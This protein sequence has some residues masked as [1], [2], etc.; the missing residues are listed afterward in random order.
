MAHQESHRENASP[1][2]A[3]RLLTLVGMTLA[4]FSGSYLAYRYFQVADWQGWLADVGFIAAVI[5]I[6]VA[7]AAIGAAVLIALRRTHKRDTFLSGEK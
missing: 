7:A 4:V 3:L 1:R 6:A 2:A 5:T